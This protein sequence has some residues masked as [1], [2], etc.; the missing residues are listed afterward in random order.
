MVDAIAA[1]LDLDPAEV[2]HRN[3]I[4]V[5]QMPYTIPLT[6]RDGT[7][8]TYDTGNYPE[9][10]EAATEAINWKSFKDK[11][12]K[13]RE[14]GVFHG[15]GIAN[16]VEPTGRGPFE[17]ATLRI[18][19]S[20][21]ITVLTGA[22]NQ[23]Q[24]NIT[25]YAQIAAEHFGVDIDQVRVVSGDTDA[26]SLGLG[27]FASRQA[28][29]AGSSIHLAAFEVA[30][31]VKKIAAILMEVS[32]ED[33]ELQNG[34]AVVNGTDLS[35]TLSEIA[36]SVAGTP[37][38]SL[39]T[40]ISPGLE[41]SSHW[42]PDELTYC[43][44]AVAAE[45][46]VDIETGEIK[47]NRLVAVHD[48]GKLINPMIV[49]G[50]IIGGSVHGVGNALFEYMAWDEEANPQPQTLVNTSYQPRQRYQK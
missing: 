26:I 34:R 38:Y 32:A 40:G 36:N 19:G 15:I 6:N 9:T 41:A 5:E 29:T 24:G 13:G 35:M 25:C 37:G 20:G 31:K 22:T 2:R 16:F 46:T 42:K 30:E 48:S 10:L 21:L 8:T 17:S 3:L 23:G 43:N 39:P 1:K 11:Q 47:I 12:K 49:D 33:I 18:G 7:L 44:G 28:V 14:D 45:V 4:P 50:Q 27:A